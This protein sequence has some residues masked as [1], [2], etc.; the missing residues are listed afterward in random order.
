MGTFNLPAS[1]RARP[2]Q[3]DPGLQRGKKIG[4]FRIH[5]SNLQSGRNPL[6]GYLS[7]DLFTEELHAGS[8]YT[9]REIMIIGEEC[10]RVLELLVGNYGLD[11]AGCERGRADTFWCHLKWMRRERDRLIASKITN[12]LADA[13]KG[14]KKFEVSL[15]PMLKSLYW[16]DDYGWFLQRIRNLLDLTNRDPYYFDYS[17]LSI[18]FENEMDAAAQQDRMAEIVAPASWASDG[19]RRES[20]ATRAVVMESRR[21]AGIYVGFQGED[22][23]T[24]DRRW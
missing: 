21:S 9:E 12:S 5:H 4:A 15:K 11:E 10:E 8:V 23:A 22:G 20:A 2:S 19:S 1:L 18:W 13:T 6:P 14:D 7:I 17:N 24:G 3:A 16:T